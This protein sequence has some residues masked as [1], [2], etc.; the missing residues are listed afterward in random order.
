MEGVSKH[1]SHLP[2]GMPCRGDAA[3][4]WLALV[5]AVGQGCRQ[6]C[7]TTIEGGNRAG[8]SVVSAAV[9]TFRDQLRPDLSLCVPT[10]RVV[11]ELS[12]DRGG[13]YNSVT[14]H[15]RLGEVHDELVYHELCH[16]VQY[17]N[18]IP[19]DGEDWTLSDAAAEE[20]GDVAAPRKEAFAMTCALALDLAFLLQ[21]ACSY[22]PAG[23]DALFEVRDLFVGPGERIDLGRAGVLTPTVSVPVTDRTFELETG[24]SA[25][26]ITTDGQEL[27]LDPWTGDVVPVADVAPLDSPTVAQVDTGLLWLRELAVPNG[28][29]T[30]RRT[31]VHDGQSVPLGCV[32]QSEV[33]FAYD[34]WLWSAWIED[35]SVRLGYWLVR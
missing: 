25:V 20:R 9:T 27:L 21:D 26:R 4:V 32:R 34:S 1:S 13:V 6:E 18:G 14:R 7:E 17:Q 11:D 33:V 12:G 10:V 16:A 31:F 29:T 22:D 2:C 8:R 5:V 35:G 19:V 30:V 28:A 3:G 23:M 15:V 24:S